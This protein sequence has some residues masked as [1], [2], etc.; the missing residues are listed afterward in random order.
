MRNMTSEQEDK[1][2]EI[3]AQGFA[4]D[5]PRSIDT[6]SYVFRKDGDIW[7]FNIDGTF[8]MNPKAKEELIESE[9]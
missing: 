7:Q 1:L 4:I 2:A 5:Y 9:Y 6:C 3:K 8:E